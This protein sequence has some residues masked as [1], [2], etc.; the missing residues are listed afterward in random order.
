MAGKTR[1]VIGGVDTHKDVHV[2]AVVDPTG[3]ILGTAS[4]PTTTAGYADLVGW[5]RR[6]GE[7]ARVGVEGT[8]AYGAGLARHLAAGSVV[9]V[10]VNRPNRQAR[11]RKGKSDTLD[12]E[13][14]AR[15]ALN[16]EATVVPKSQSG[17]V[18]SIR[19]L[20]VAYTS[21]RGSRT[22][23]ANQIRDLI[24]SAPDELRRTLDPLR[25]DERVQRCARFQLGDPTDPTEATKTALKSLARRHQGLTEEMAELHG[26]LDRLTAEAN[27][28]LRGAKGVGPDVAAILLTA[29][30]DNP[31]RMKSEA[32]FAALCGSSPVEASSG[33]VVRHRLNRGGNRQA[34][35]ALWRMAMVR[36][37][38]DDATKNYFVRRRAE[39]KTDREIIRCLKRHIARE[40]YQYLVNPQDVPAGVDL[41]VRRVAAG[42][43]LAAASSELGTSINHICRVERAIEHDAELGRRYE[44]WLDAVE[45]TAGG[46][47]AL[48][49]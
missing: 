30:G 23:I 36:M 1:V 5:M 46:G 47:Q 9:V 45:S 2:A 39:Q 33:K 26:G 32:A 10:E 6:F 3:R 44:K 29:A 13:A 40:V 20:R 7:V 11:R 41:R 48:V 38:T 19:V 22:R 21:A 8:G 12:A 35:H 25:V 14:A 31:E 42:L 18:E 17:V 34:N 43:T 37:T 16:G 24:V 15:A 4:F 28:E 49:A 27:P